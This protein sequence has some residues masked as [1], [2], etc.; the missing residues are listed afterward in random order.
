MARL[1]VEQ[2]APV[3]ALELTQVILNDLLFAVEQAAA[4]N[5]H[6]YAKQ[7]LTQ[8][9]HARAQLYREYGG[10]GRPLR[11]PPDPLGLLPGAGGGDQRAALLTASRQAAAAPATQQ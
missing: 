9:E 5:E 10:P 8:I 3:I 1:F 2:A 6:A 7:L 11:Q 4:L